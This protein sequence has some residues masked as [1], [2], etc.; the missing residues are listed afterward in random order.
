MSPQETGL[1]GLGALVA[2]LALGCPVGL[3]LIAVGA[4]GFAVIVGPGPALG[5][6]ER[7]V[8]DTASNQIGR[9]HV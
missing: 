3:A 8:T 9:A 5:I 6:L 1:A 4:G 7:S 2:L